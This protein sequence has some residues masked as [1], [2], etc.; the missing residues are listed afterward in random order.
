MSD[1]SDVGEQ[2]NAKV[3]ERNILAEMSGAVHLLVSHWAI[4]SLWAIS[5]SYVALVHYAGSYGLVGWFGDG[6]AIVGLIPFQLGAVLIFSFAFVL[7]SVT[8][9][10]MFFS[11][12]DKAWFRWLNFFS[13]SSGLDQSKKN[14]IEYGVL[15]VFFASF[16]FITGAL[17]AIIVF[18]IGIG[19]WSR[20]VILVTF[21]A[22]LV[23]YGSFVVA[24]EELSEHRKKFI[25]R[26]YSNYLAM[27]GFMFFLSVGLVYVNFADV[28]SFRI[29]DNYSNA[30]IFAAIA[31][32]F[33][34]VNTLVLVYATR[35]VA[36]NPRNIVLAIGAILSFSLLAPKSGA[37]ITGRGLYLIGNGGEVVADLRISG[38]AEAANALI[39]SLQAEGPTLL[40]GQNVVTIQAAIILD[41]GGEYFY[42]RV[43][44]TGSTLPVLV[45]REHVLATGKS[46]K[47]CVL[48][49]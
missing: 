21:V 16:P 15:V 44:G 45:R 47:T 18:F 14:P 29:D 13:G 34:V 9:I 43:C 22:L 8:P 31:V 24:D 17:S 1:A 7:F 30:K 25:E 39:S 2:A 35:E 33:G 12:D 11:G 6:K 48:S 49:N 28:P 10:V 36:V 23:L 38:S 4:F 20:F 40:L 5:V 42:V 3:G 19:A 27:M 37:L 26:Q 46:K 32:F 41:S